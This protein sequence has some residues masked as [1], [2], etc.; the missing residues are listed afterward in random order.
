LENFQDEIGYVAKVR[1]PMSHYHV[2]GLISSMVL[3]LIV[4]PMVYAVMDRSK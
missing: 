1:T 2:A 4:I 3:T